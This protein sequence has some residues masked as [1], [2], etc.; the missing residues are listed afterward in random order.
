[1]KYYE[2]LLILLYI[3][4]IDEILC[5]RHSV[6]PVTLSKYVAKYEQM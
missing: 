6:E 5:D 4:M 1:M 3:I 2:I